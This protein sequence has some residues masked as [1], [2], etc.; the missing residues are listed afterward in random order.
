MGKYNM[1]DDR[2][3]LKAIA[4]K[5]KEKALEKVKLQGSNLKRKGIEG[6]PIRKSTS[7]KKLRA[8]NEGDGVDP[9]QGLTPAIVVSGV[10]ED[11]GKGLL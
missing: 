3:R 6:D 10:E 4:R 5:K 7:I 9:V 8:S 2:E 1:P 11:K